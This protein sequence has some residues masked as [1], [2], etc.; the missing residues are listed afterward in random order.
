MPITVSHLDA[1]RV[2][3][4]S[5]LPASSRLTRL[6]RKTKMSVEEIMNGNSV[7][8]MSNAAVPRVRKRKRPTKIVALN[9]RRAVE[10]GSL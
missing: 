7:V 6:I 8:M 4:Y 1:G 10:Y 5:G 3:A 2:E 9:C